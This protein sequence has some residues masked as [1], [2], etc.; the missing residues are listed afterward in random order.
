MPEEV[1]VAAGAEIL[2][3]P[4]GG[5]GRHAPDEPVLAAPET[6]ISGDTADEYDAWEAQ[7]AHRGSTSPDSG[8]GH[9][10]LLDLDVRRPGM[11]LR[12]DSEADVILVALRAAE[13]GE[14]GGKRLDEGRIAHLDQAGHITAYEFIGASRGVSLTGID[15]DDAGQIREAIR[16]LIQLAV[17]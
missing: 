15:M 5:S 4:N 2:R 7:D 3:R 1:A 11:Q 9:H 13:G 14:A 10:C 17:A 6:V 12:Y 16:P 8:T